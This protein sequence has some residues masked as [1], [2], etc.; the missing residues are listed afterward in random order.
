MD[1]K[2][3]HTRTDLSCSIL[4]SEWTTQTCT[5]SVYRTKVPGIRYTVQQPG[6]FNLPPTSGRQN[7]RGGE[8]NILK[9][10]KLFLFTKHVFN[11]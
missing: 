4:Y 8:M 7:P 10:K 6:H 3:I 11:Y 9:E 5:I 2:V 1:F